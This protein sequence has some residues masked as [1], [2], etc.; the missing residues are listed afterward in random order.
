[1]PTQ[2]STDTRTR[3]IDAAAELFHATV[4][5]MGLTGH[6]LEVALRMQR[7][8]TPWIYSEAYRLPDIDA[9]LDGLKASAKDW[10]FTVAWMDSL[11]GNGRGHLLCGRGGRRW[12]LGRSRRVPAAPGADLPLTP[13]G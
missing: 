7:V 11:S 8:P 3:I 13:P 1:M 4:G 5:G 2:R 12:G 6:I 9:L 10:T